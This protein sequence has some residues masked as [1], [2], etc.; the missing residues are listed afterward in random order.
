M[1]APLSICTKE[2]RRV[3]V[4]FLFAQVQT[5]YGAA[6]LDGSLHPNDYQG[7]RGTRCIKVLPT[8]SY[9]ALDTSTN[10]KPWKVKL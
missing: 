7:R 5:D 1:A 4:R 6:M 2:E 9:S 8:I 3:S 10:A